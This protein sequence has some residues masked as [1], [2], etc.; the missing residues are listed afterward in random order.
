MTFLQMTRLRL[1][2]LNKYWEDNP[3]EK[4]MLEEEKKTL[5]EKRNSIKSKID[6]INNVNKNKLEVFNKRLPCEIEVDNQIQLSCAI[7]CSTRFSSHM[8]WEHCI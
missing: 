7:I 4:E 6:E 2:T 8:S 1:K 5:Y 3:K